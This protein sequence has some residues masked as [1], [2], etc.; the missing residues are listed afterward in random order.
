MF[1]FKC[2]N[3][4]FHSTKTQT[5]P[6]HDSVK[7]FFNYKSYSPLGQCLSDRKLICFFFSCYNVYD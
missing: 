5:F 3:H 2:G 1:D 7:P 4:S 6:G